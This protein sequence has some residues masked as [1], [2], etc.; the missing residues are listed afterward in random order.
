MDII[1]WLDTVPQV[2]K[3]VFN[4]VSRKW[5]G[6]TYYVISQEINSNRKLINSESDFGDAIIVFLYESGDYERAGLDFIKEHPDAFHII[7]GYK[8]KTAVFLKYLCENKTTNT[9]ILIW[10]ERPLPKWKTIF[11][12]SLFHTKFAWKYREKIDAFLPLGKE[13]IKMYSKLGWKKEKMFP[14]LY[15][16]IMNEHLPKHINYSD[17]PI[18]FVYLG[19]FSES[20]GVDV[21]MDACEEIADME[22]QI[23][24]VGG[25]GPI[26]DRV[27]KWCDNFRQAQFGGTW[28]IDEAVDRLYEYD[29]CIIPSKYDGWN[30]TVNEALMA[31]IGVIVT[32]EA[33]SDE[34]VSSSK[35]GMV[36]PAG[37]KRALSKAM[38][39]VILDQALVARWKNNAYAYRN[40]MTADICAEYFVSIL[41]YIMNSESERPKA[42]WI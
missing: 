33:V 39:K 32:N 36:V 14:F 21:L 1:F 28:P 4:E 40:R 22:Y 17:D 29:A 3:G 11:P 41:K 38:K 30:V 2:C 8:S 42:P 18:R 24:L 19:R 20:K 35:A 9:K 23:T 16:P 27:L 26:K 10:A 6:K 31:G 37:D 15:L 34:M 13:G 5:H 12:F 25:Y 7:N